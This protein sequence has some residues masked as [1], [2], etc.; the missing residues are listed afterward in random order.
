MVC[1]WGCLPSMLLIS[2]LALCNGSGGESGGFVSRCYERVF[3]MFASKPYRTPSGKELPCK[4]MIPVRSCWGRCDS[5]EIPDYRIPYKISNH[6]VCTYGGLRERTLTLTHCH[7]L[8]PDP[9]YTVYDATHCI[10]GSCDSEFTSCEN[11][12]G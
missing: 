3:K 1:L 4:D 10:C 6:S 9:T 12:N 8:H 2:F 11:L 5:S 7:P